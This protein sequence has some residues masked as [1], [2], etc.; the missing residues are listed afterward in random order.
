MRRRRRTAAL[1][2]MHA[3]NGGVI[4]VIVQRALAEGKTRAEVPRADAPDDGG[5]EATAPRHRAGRDG[6][7]AGLHRASLVRRRAR[8][9]A[10]GA[11]PRPARLR[12]NLPAVSLPL[13][14]EHGRAGLRGRQVRLHAAAAREVAPGQALAGPGA[15]N[16]LQVVSTDHCPFCFKEQ[17]ELGKDDFTKIPNGGPGIENRL[18]LVYHRTG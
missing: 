17:K 7:R 11:R 6:R 8:K 9:S 3:E 5:G 2:C 16:T 18:S 1:I 13:A 10:R 14:R 15:A 12:G 4:D